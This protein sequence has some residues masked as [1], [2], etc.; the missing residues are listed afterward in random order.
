MKRRQKESW[1]LLAVLSTATGLSARDPE[2]QLQMHPDKARVTWTLPP[3][4]IANSLTTR[5]TRL[6]TST[7]LKNWVPLGSEVS[8]APGG[9]VQAALDVLQPGPKRYFRV[10][11]VETP[12]FLASGGADVF[13]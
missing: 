5:R 3:G 12:Q 1:L 13:G 6:E 11:V 7:D 4:Q 10:G 2:V 9:P 8:S